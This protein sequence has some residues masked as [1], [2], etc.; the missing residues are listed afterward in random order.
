MNDKQKHSK[1][2]ADM[3]AHEEK[4]MQKV[5]LKKMTI[6]DQIK[7]VTKDIAEPHT[8]EDIRTALGQLGIVHSL[9]DIQDSMQTKTKS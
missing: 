6:A 4:H 1:A 8:A 7:Q 5:K 3:L 2:E 9:K